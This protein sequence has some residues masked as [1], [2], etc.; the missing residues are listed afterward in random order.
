MLPDLLLVLGGAASGKSK[1]AE[2]RVLASGLLPIYVA[3]AKAY[4]D[5]MKEKI[6]LHQSRRGP[7]W[8]N[9]EAPLDLGPAL[10]TVTEK[11]ACLI[12][13]ATLWLTNHLLAEH[14]ICVR[15]EE[16]LQAIGS[17][18]G[19]VVV[20]SNE[21]GQGIVPDNRLARLFREEQGRL[22][23]RLAEA[24]DSVVM[25]TAGLPMVLKDRM[26]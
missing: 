10:A 19:P 8:I 2:S 24:A 14:D 23:I 6:K 26:P 5:E 21:V 15:T 12:D 16:I 25:V 3:T 9:L 18:R 11:H 7:E 22:N 20:V 4:D 17:A 1:F 13:C